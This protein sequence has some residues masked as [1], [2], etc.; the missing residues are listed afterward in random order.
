MFNKKYPRSNSQLITTLHIFSN[1]WEAKHYIFFPVHSVYSDAEYHTRNQSFSN[2]GSAE[3]KKSDGGNTMNQNERSI[4][5]NRND[6]TNYRRYNWTDIER[7]DPTDLQA[8]L[9]NLKPYTQYEIPHT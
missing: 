9:T 1:S 6:A 2:V 4:S 8:K 3:D 5:R 7:V